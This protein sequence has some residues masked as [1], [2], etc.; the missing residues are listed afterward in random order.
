MF[1]KKKPKLLTEILI[2]FVNIVT[3]LILIMKSFVFLVAQ[4]VRKKTLITL[5]IM[6]SKKE[7][8]KQKNQIILQFKHKMNLFNVKKSENQLLS[9]LHLNFQLVMF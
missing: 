3:V 6:R 1:Q 5:K 2:G 4:L 7:R 9:L 8:K